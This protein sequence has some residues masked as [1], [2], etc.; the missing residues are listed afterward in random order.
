M[1]NRDL[2]SYFSIWKTFFF[3][4]RSIYFLT[5]L[6]GHPCCIPKTHICM[7]LYLSSVF[8][9][10][11]YICLFQ[12][13]QHLVLITVVSP[14]KK[15]HHIQWGNSSIFPSMLIFFIKVLAIFPLLLFYLNFIISLS[16][17]IEIHANILIGTLL[18]WGDGQ[19]YAIVF[20]FTM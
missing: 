14:K 2:I 8:N 1:W 19:H 20:L 4:T 17:S 11:L 10:I 7:G 3:L 9:T 6:A 18:N 16:S 13:L 15:K 12:C 5:D